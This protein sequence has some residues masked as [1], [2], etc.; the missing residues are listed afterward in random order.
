MEG[1]IARARLTLL[2][3]LLG[4]LSLLWVAL[5]ESVDI[6]ALGRSIAENSIWMGTQFLPES[7]TT[8]HGYVMA[9]DTPFMPDELVRITRVADILEM[10]QG[11]S[12]ADLEGLVENNDEVGMQMFRNL[13]TDINRLETLFYSSG[14]PQGASLGHLELRLKKTIKIPLLNHIVPAARACTAWG[15]AFL[16]LM[17]YFSGLIETIS[18]RA[19]LVENDKGIDFIF[20]H[21][22]WVSPLLGVA[23]L[24]SPA[25]AFYWVSAGRIVEPWKGFSAMAVLFLFALVLIRR[26]AL[27]RSRFFQRLAELDQ[28]LPTQ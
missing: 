8:Y 17:T 25:F 23:W 27:A 19:P 24:F 15:L 3:L 6:I 4:S 16:I 1:L 22:S 13:R 5:E 7:L 18:Y 26:V 21:C 11:L 12:Y 14:L 2:G 10:R 20:F 28:R 9:D